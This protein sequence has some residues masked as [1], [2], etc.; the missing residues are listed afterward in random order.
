MTNFKI[1]GDQQNFAVQ[2]LEL[3]LFRIPGP[4]SSLMCPIFPVFDNGVGSNPIRADVLNPSWLD[5]T[6]LRDMSWIRSASITKLIVSGKHF[7]PPL[8]CWFTHSLYLSHCWKTGRIRAI[9]DNLHW[10]IHKFNRSGRN[11]FSS[12]LVGR[13]L[14]VHAAQNKAE[15]KGD[16]YIYGSN[17]E[18]VGLLVTPTANAPKHSRAAPQAVSKAICETSVLVSRRVTG[19]IYVVLH[20]NISKTHACKTAEEIM[21]LYSRYPFYITNTNFGRLIY[22]YQSTRKLV[23]SQ[24]HLWK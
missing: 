4:Y 15:K 10:P 1:P 13:I 23:K 14:M 3:Q 12:V 8:Y 7:P 24:L 2:D 6:R 16:S 11:L 21:H 22:T 18:G 9:C 20:K 5:C 19:L 17:T